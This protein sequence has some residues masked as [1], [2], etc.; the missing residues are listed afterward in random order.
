M[1]KIKEILISKNSSLQVVNT[2]CSATK[3]RQ[4]SLVNLCKDVD[5]V[6]VVGGK[7]S[8]NT[9]RLY[10]IAKD[11]CKNVFYIETENEITKEM[12]A[13]ERIGITAGASTPDELIC[14]VENK[15]GCGIY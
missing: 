1:K 10:Q 7:N 15:L 13:F 12:F 11:N 8:A 6:F 9:N 5:A 2:I 3:E 14:A 4:E